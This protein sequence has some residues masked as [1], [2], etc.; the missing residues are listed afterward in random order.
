L[1]ECNV[2]QRYA[3]SPQTKGKIERHYQWVQ[4]HLIRRCVSDK[5][6]YIKN[7]QQVLNEEVKL[8]DYKR[9]HSITSEVSYYRFQKAKQDGNNLFTNFYI[10]PKPFIPKKTSFLY[11]LTNVLTD[12]G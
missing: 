6:T 1:K 5:I 10:L 2:K 11:D 12:T 9:I 8:Y 4:D 7:G 3:L